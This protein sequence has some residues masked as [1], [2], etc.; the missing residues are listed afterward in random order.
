MAYR[1]DEDLEFLRSMQSKDLDAL[2][3]ILTGKDGDRRLTEELTA[4]PLYKRFYPE[5]IE[6]VEEVME[7]L[8]L[9]GGNTII[10]KA[11]GKGVLYR[12]IL[13]D[14]C[15]KAKVN[16]N[17]KSPVERIEGE[18]L[19]K[20]LTQAIEKMDMSEIES[21]ASELESIAKDAKIG[22]AKGLTKQGAIAATQAAVL[23][24][25][26]GSYQLALIVANAVAKQ[27]L[28]RGLSLAANA[29][30]T[31]AISV[32]AGPIGW[33]ITVLWTALDIA[34]AAFRVTTPAVIQV[35]FLRSLKTQREQ[36]KEHAQLYQ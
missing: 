21:I 26:F 1:Y 29:G 25:G 2:V 35:A 10:N 7:E 6:Y 33:A 22:T 24:G 19:A 36:D 17:K 3:E 34:G 15:D 14:V 28:G 13:C 5:H 4:N 23:A 9:F 31:R 11:R 16:Y 27:V 12:E 18:L 8:Q 32:F 30:L 20:I